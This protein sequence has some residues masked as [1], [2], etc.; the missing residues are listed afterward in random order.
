MILVEGEVKWFDGKRA[1]G[2]I[3]TVEFF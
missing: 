3:S 1:S 2:R